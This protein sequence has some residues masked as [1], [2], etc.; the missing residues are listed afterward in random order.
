MYVLNKKIIIYL[1]RYVREKISWVG[2]GG[3]VKILYHNILTP[4]VQVTFLL[5]IASLF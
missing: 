3:G 5:I 4:H 1:L 2:G